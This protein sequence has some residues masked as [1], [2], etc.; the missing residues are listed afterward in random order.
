MYARYD[1][2]WHIFFFSSQVLPRFKAVLVK[3]DESYPYGDKQNEFKKLAEATIS[4]EDLLIAEVNVRGNL[5]NI[6]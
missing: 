6:L 1:I 2:I 5:I 3:F 4:Q